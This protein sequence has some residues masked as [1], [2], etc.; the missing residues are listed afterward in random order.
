LN[1]ALSGI[2]LVLKLLNFDGHCEVAVLGRVYKSLQ[3]NLLLSS[4][5]VI[6]LWDRVN[7]SEDE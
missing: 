1:E 7:I 6:V 5:V 3:L 2:V 4:F